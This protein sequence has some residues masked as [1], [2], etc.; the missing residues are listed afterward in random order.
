[1]APGEKITI[2][3]DALEE[4]MRHHTLWK[5]GKREEAF[6]YLAGLIK[7]YPDNSRLL[8]TMA[9]FQFELGSREQAWKTLEHSMSLDPEHFDPHVTKAKLL[10][11]EGL[12]TEG[13]EELLT[14]IKTK[15]LQIYLSILLAADLCLEYGFFDQAKELYTEGFKRFPDQEDFWHRYCKMYLDALRLEEYYEALV[16]GVEKR[17]DDAH[18][19]FELTKWAGL[20]EKEEMGKKSVKVLAKVIDQ[21]AEGLV[22]LATGYAAV[23]DYVNAE[24]AIRESMKKNDR[25][26]RAWVTYACIMRLKGQEIEAKRAFDRASA[27]GSQFREVSSLLQ[28]FSPGI[29]EKWHLIQLENGNNRMKEAIESKD[30]NVFTQ[31]MAEIYQLTKGDFL[32][33]A[34][35]RDFPQQP[36]GDSYYS[37]LAVIMTLMKEPKKSIGMMYKA[38]QQSPDNPATLGNYANILVSNQAFSGAVQ[39]IEKAQS[40]DASRTDLDPFY[41]YSLAQ[42][43]EPEK[44]IVVLEKVLQKEPGNEIA[45]Q[46]LPTAY[47][48]LKRY[49]DAVKHLDNALKKIPKNAKLFASM[50]IAAHHAG[51]KKKSQK[52]LKEC[53]K[54]DKTLASQIESAIKKGIM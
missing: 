3:S 43:Q 22:K 1:M 5:E 18:L 53:K 33:Y 49:D 54:L 10:M 30:N 36:N 32:V 4:F 52:A 41:G 8:Q 37:L 16:E 29:L 50:A 34:A 39:V 51:D 42:S 24:W 35:D 13:L 21:D 19:W 44:A 11:L 12:I 31:K 26:G 23:K 17:P 15:K 28:K 14:N 40:L 6:N 45:L 48:A 25:D 38:V 7:K 46:V 9:E 20:L 2:S 27:L 47:M